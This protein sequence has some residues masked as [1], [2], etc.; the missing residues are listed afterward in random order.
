MLFGLSACMG[1]LL[2]LMTF[3]LENGSLWLLWMAMISGCLL[4]YELSYSLHCI[5]KKLMGKA[6]KNLNFYWQKLSLK[7]KRKVLVSK[8]LTNLV[9]MC[10]SLLHKVRRASCYW[11]QLDFHHCN[12]WPA[13]RKSWVHFDNRKQSGEL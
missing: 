2:L 13:P 11:Y 9:K 4:T 6:E 10:S 8:L 12:H 5:L 7:Y 1:F 3:A